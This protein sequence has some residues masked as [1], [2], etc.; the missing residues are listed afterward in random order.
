MEA[1]MICHRLVILLLLA[2]IVAYQAAAQQT[3][4]SLLTLDRI[5]TSKEFAPQPLGPVQ[6][7]ESGSSYTRLEPT[8]TAK[9]AR[10]IVRYET[11]TGRREVLVAAERLIPTGSSA[12]LAIDNYTFSPNGKL[13]LIY[14]NLQ[15]VWRQNTRGD[16]WVLDIGA[17][18]LTKLGGDAKPATLMFAKFSPD[19]TRVGYVRENNIYVETLADNRITRLTEDG[20]RKIINGTFDWVYEE[21]LDLRDGWRWSP[22]GN[23]IAYWQLNSEGVREFYLLNNTDSLYP[24]ITAIPYPKAGETNS[25]SRVG[26]VGAQGGPTRWL[27]VPGDPR[28]HYI[29][30][31]N[32]AESSD[33]VALQQLNRLQNTNLVMLGDIH[34]GKVRTILTERDEAW[35]DLHGD[36][37]DWLD[38]GK[39]FLWISERDGWRHAYVVSRDGATIKLITPGNFDVI[40]VVSADEKNGWLYFYSSPENATQ[41]YLYRAR[42]DGTG[43]PECVTPAAQSGTH[44]YNISPNSSWAFHSFSSFGKSPQI[45]LVRLPGHARVRSVIDN[46]ALSDKLNRLKCGTSEFFKVD[47]GGGVQLDGWMIKPPDFDPAKHYPVLFHVYGEPAGQTVLDAWGGNNY[48]WHLMLSQR[49]YVV[50]SVDNRGTPAPKGRAWRKVVYRQ[51]GLLASVEQAAAA[52][53][54]TKWRFVDASRIGIWGWSGGGSMTL[55]MMFRYPEIYKTGM[56]VAPVSNERLYDSIYQERY[57]GLPRDNEENY[58]RGSPVNFADKLQGK[59]LVVHGSGDDNVHYQNTEVLINA[60]IAAN[61][62]FTMMEYPNRTHA[63]NEGPNTS[64]HLFELLT[65]YLQQNLPAGPR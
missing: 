4:P 38:G 32:W 41:R 37:I 31:M 15:R 43:K 7:V 16:Y 39:R 42:L 2:T 62:P 55:N 49:G 52:R 61:K 40:S 19:S 27:D 53:V 60:L 54:I 21:E 64:R 9:D 34:T 59:L 48:L 5:F 3:D 44:S 63:I 17:E 14:T 28:D 13:L 18:K 50:V 24:A 6:W 65:R 51:V 33:Q 22:D 8:A 11:E 12:P 47:V 26:I 58:K 20:S 23:R 10:D 56:S 29:A 35:V 45:E 1:G 25:A 30:R 57:M 36:D 46:A